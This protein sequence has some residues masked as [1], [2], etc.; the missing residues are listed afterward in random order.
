MKSTCSQQLCCSVPWDSIEARGSA[1]CSAQS[2]NS[3]YLGREGFVAF[4]EAHLNNQSPLCEI[5][6]S[7]EDI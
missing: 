6:W 4:S 3:S 1:A 7:I 5:E 2:T